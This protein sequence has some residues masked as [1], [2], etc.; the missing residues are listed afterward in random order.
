MHLTKQHMY[1]H[2]PPISKTIQVRQTRHTGDCWR[3]KDELNNDVL[4]WT[5]THEH[6]SVDR[7]K[8]TY[9]H[10]LC[11]D[12]GCSL[13]DLPVAM[14]NRGEWRER[15]RERERESE[16]ERE[17]EK[18]REWVWE[19][20][21]ERE[22][23]REWV[24]ERER[25][26]ERESQGNPC[27]QCD[28]MMMAGVFPVPLLILQG[29]LDFFFSPGNCTIFLNRFEES[30]PRV[31]ANVLDCDIVV[32]EFELQSCYYVHFWESYEPLIPTNYGLNI[33]TTVLL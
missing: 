15:E 24:W 9:L 28:L 1:G 4:L 3:S 26:R 6:A 7:L 18:E 11:A 29:S 8:R 17:K 32:S 16:C 12:T 5:L 2:L 21:R 13:E 27:C 14:D 23:E 22:R 10:Q 19:R 25:E 33:T 31:V 20:E 30:P